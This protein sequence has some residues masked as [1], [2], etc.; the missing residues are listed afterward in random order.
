MISSVSF[1]PIISLSSWHILLTYN[2]MLCPGNKL[3]YRSSCSCYLKAVKWMFLMKGFL[4]ISI[5]V[6][7]FWCFREMQFTTSSGYE[8]ILRNL[9]WLFILNFIY[10]LSQ[11]L[12]SP[13]SS[14]KTQ[15]TFNLKMEALHKSY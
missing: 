5:I 9:F 14:H 4:D 10:F 3:I 13:L 8:A 1:S 7:A 11:N 2:L 15:G 12:I 6:L